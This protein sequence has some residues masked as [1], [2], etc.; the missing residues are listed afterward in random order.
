MTLY[1]SSDSLLD[2]TFVQ[3]EEII[4]ITWDETKYPNIFTKGVYTIRINGLI[5][6][7]SHKNG[8]MSIFFRRVYDQA[9][10]L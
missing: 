1:D 7:T 3:T 9:I 8:V 6:P 4:Q 5:T 2:V 10:V